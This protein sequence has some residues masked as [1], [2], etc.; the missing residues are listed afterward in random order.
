MKTCKGDHG[1]CDRPAHARGY[2][3]AHYQRWYRGGDTD[4]SVRET[5]GRPP[6]SHSD[7]ARLRRE[8][9]RIS[10]LARR[11]EDIATKIG[12]RLD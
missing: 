5:R 6:G 10:V 3:K 2:C 1:N 8:A 7:N 4:S 11:I 9:K 12:G